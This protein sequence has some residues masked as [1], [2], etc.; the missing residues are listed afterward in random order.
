MNL[1]LLI[2]I[3]SLCSMSCMAMDL[4]SSMTTAE[5]KMTGYDSLTKE[6]KKEL[7]LWLTKNTM[8]VQKS[9]QQAALSLNINIDGGR[10]LILSDGTIWE[11]APEDQSI[12]NLWL[13]P[14][15]LNLLPGGSPEYPNVLMNADAEKEKVK[16]RQI[17]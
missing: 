5:K 12:S 13:T 16:V 7:N 4:D 10:Q 11:V 2:S 14:I 8:P 6:Q 9:P 3:F 15:P 17:H 1:T